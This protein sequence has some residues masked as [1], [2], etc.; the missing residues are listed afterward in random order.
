MIKYNEP[1]PLLKCVEEALIS[2]LTKN[3]TLSLVKQYIQFCNNKLN[4]MIDSNK[5]N[6]NPEEIPSIYEPDNSYLFITT[7]NPPY[8]RT[9]KKKTFKY[10]I[11]ITKNFNKKS[12]FIL[13]FT[14]WTWRIN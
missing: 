14:N 9:T 2:P 3:N 5:G 1:K 7:K 10:I 11:K 12:F 6:A 4:D 8:N 13:F